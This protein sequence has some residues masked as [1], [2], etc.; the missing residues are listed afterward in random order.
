MKAEK[1]VLSFVALL[2]G[3]I[4]AGG[5]FY[6]LQSSKGAKPQENSPKTE[7]VSPTQTPS[8]NLSITINSP[9]DEEVVTKK[10]VTVSGK[11]TGAS[12]VV[13]STPL[14]DDVIEPSANGDFTATITIDNGYNELLFTAIA[15]TGEEVRKTQT[16][17][18]S[19]EEF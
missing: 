15:P 1:V 4:V 17:T 13:I 10:L 16:I 2:L 18:Y 9:K 14:A 3:L 8:S 19:T 5:A 7:S 6:F 12:V 11:T